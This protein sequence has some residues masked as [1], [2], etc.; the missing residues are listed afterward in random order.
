[1]DKNTLKSSFRDRLN[2]VAF[3]ADQ[4]FFS[5]GFSFV[6]PSSVLP[7]FVDQFTD[8]APVIGSVTT[9]LTGGWL[10]PQLIASRLTDERTRRRLYLVLP[11][12]G[13]TSFWATALGLAAGL[14]GYPTAML[15][16]FFVAY[17]LFA[18]A[19]GFASVPWFD[20]L[21][22]AVPV[23]RRGRLLGTAQL[24]G[25]L[26]GAGAG[27]LVSLVLASPRLGFP[28]N[29]ALIFTLASVLFLP[30]LVART[31]I[32]EPPPT[33]VRNV[34]A[35]DRDRGSL[36]ATLGDPVW[37][38]VMACRLLVGM[39]AMA[40]PFYVVHA[41]REIGM[42]ASVIGSFVAAGMLSRAAAA[43]LLGWVSER[44]GPRYVIGAGSV[45]AIAGPLFAL[46]VDLAPNGGLTRAYPFI[47]VT[48]GIVQGSMVLGFLNY[49]MEIAPSELR[50]SYI[51]L[52]NTIMAVV[53][54]A[55]ILGGWL[56]EATSYSLLFAVTAAIVTSGF[57][58]ALTLEPAAATPLGDLPSVPG[59][60]TCGSRI[61]S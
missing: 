47:Y 51:G 52:T 32:R 33:T 16:L 61:H 4:A 60:A 22:R 20:L 54:L 57:L 5:I 41:S 43:P 11:M 40:T 18:L 35:G 36:I 3:F 56:L 23:S 13:R 44:L 58:V 21:A 19:D 31:L 1:M 7:V 28:I 46:V 9:I 27:A 8:S 59:E 17:G 14:G 24:A 26:G 55:P 30:S 15:T 25:S 45:A 42:S 34:D 48:L 38:R 50:P 37:R 12:L 29:Y 10:L 2:S 49:V 39:R 53:M 6:D